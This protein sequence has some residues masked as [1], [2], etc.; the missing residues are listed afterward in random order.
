MIVEEKNE[1][2]IDADGVSWGHYV[3]KGMP[4]NASLGTD[5]LGSCFAF[6]RID[7]DIGKV[8]F[9][10]VSSDGENDTLLNKDFKKTTDLTTPADKEIQ[11]LYVKGSAPNDN[12]NRRI[13][14][15]KEK[16]GG[17][18]YHKKDYGGVALSPFKKSDV[19]IKITHCKTITA[20]NEEQYKNK[21]EQAKQWPEYH[22]LEEM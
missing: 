1:D 6:I 12:T 15:L 2:N 16:Y 13:N 8:F 5:S 4:T 14:K 7:K 18:I 20:S 22:G 11:F 9:A 3:D 19:K 17:N 10:H 21:T